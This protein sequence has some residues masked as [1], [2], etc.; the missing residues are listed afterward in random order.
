MDK[1]KTTP[2][3]FFLW[4]GA[5]VAFYW[6][7]VAF[8]GLIFDYINYAFPNAL[9]YYPN[10]PYQGGISYEMASLIVLFPLFVILMR[11]IHGD[12]VRDT[13]RSEIWVRRWAL[14]LT[15]FIAG[16]SM[17]GDIIVLLTSFLN[18]SDLTTAFLL[19]VAVVFLVAAATFMHFVADY[20]GY[21]EKNP[22][23]GHMVGYVTGLL[24]LLTIVAGFFIVGTPQH[25]RQMRMDDTRVNDLQQIQ[26]EVTTYYQQ[27]R[28]LPTTLA[29]LNDPLFYNVIPVDPET[30]TP[31]EYIKN[32]DLGFQVCAIFSAQSSTNIGRTMPVL[33]GGNPQPDNWS[34][35]AGRTCFTRS[36]DPDFF[37][38]YPKGQ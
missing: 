22:S 17:A 7:V 35:T 27:K 34:H 32:S 1:P 25:A 16:A 10:D 15:L 36:I 18:G 21:W 20:R 28:A 23:R 38:P 33:V 5:M 8:L 31:Y 19:K 14:F 11:I 30:G 4:A 29:Q 13:S 2:K 9:S 6:S 3:D 26:S 24:A 12:I 37:P